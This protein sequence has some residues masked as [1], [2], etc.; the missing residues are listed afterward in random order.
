MSNENN[1]AS[2]PRRP[3]FDCQLLP[4][5]GY[6][7]L[8]AILSSIAWLASLAQDG[9]DYAR[10]TGPIVSDITQS[11]SIPYLEV[12]FNAYRH[13]T[14]VPEKDAWEVVY[15]SH[16]IQYPDDEV[17]RDGY[18]SIS[19]GFAFLALVFG[20]GGALFLWFS[21]CFVF[22]PGTWRW[23]GY[24]VLAASLF[25]TLTFLWFKTEM[26]SQGE[27]DACSLF[28]GSKS[29]ILAASFWFAAALSIFF[30]Y[31]APTPKPGDTR[32]GMPA[33]DVEVAENS[34]EG[35]GTG[36]ELPLEGDA[37]QTMAGPDNDKALEDA[38]VKIPD[39][40]IS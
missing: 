24:E 37:T 21:S 22:S 18:W 36:L 26:C 34:I 27:G 8:P 29:D 2:P 14:Y 32:S 12:G 15:V 30:R 33:E 17:T 35:N 3:G 23:A 4:H 31:P 28:F 19:K 40:E 16:C 10:L 11:S 13:P 20:G 5:G 6:T 39:R 25:Q 9:C 38:G 7:L 1:N